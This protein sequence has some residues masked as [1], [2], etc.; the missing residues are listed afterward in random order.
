MVTKP[1]RGQSK[2]PLVL[3]ALG[4][5]LVLGAAACAGNV[6]V[7]N[8]PLPTTASA[9]Q[10]TAAENA[11][12]T[13]GLQILPTDTPSTAAAAVPT[14]TTA[15]GG[16]VSFARD[17]LPILQAYCSGCHG[18][19][20]QAAGLDFSSYSSLMNGRPVVVPNDPNNS[21]LLQVVIAGIMPRGGNSLSD[22]QI[23]TITDWINAGAPNN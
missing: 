4:L 22:Q 19:N 20:R 17:V 5:A 11:T 9:S 10:P 15:A 6:P 14:A 1:V 7:T 13:S 18:T 12:A 8:I 21:E 3:V 23:Q 16:T 2:K